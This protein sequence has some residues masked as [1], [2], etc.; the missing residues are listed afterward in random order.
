MDILRHSS[1]D[2]RLSKLIISQF[3]SY[4][5]S[6]RSSLCMREPTRHSLIDLW[7]ARSLISFFPYK[8]PEKERKKQ[9]K[10]ERRISHYSP[11]N[12]AP[13]SCHEGMSRKRPRKLVNVY[14]R[15]IAPVFLRPSSPHRGSHRTYVL[16]TSGLAWDL[17]SSYS[18]LARQKSHVLEVRGTEGPRNT[19]NMGH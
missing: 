14:V 19:W 18:C 3:Q 16:G 4:D 1:K 8:R 17:R 15:F 11:I 13:L 12:Q 2:E 10:H 9:L 5:R 6:L 7:L